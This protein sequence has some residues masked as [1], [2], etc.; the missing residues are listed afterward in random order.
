MDIKYIKNFKLLKLKNITYPKDMP[1]IQRLNMIYN[2]NKNTID[3]FCKDNDLNVTYTLNKFVKICKE[4]EKE[5][6]QKEK[7]EKEKE[8]KQKEKLEKQNI[9]L[10]QERKRLEKIQDLPTIKDSIRNSIKNY[11]RPSVTKR[12]SKK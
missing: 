10:E 9:I 11:V 5:D 6:K 12:I 2:D 7:L 3:K 8:D 4:K 1:C